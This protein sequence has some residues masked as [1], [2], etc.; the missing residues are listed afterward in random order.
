MIEH[1]KRQAVAYNEGLTY[2]NGVHIY[3][4]GG[5][6]TRTGKTVKV[7]TR[8]NIVTEKWQQLSPTLFDKM[9]AAACAIN[10]Y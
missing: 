2:Y 8:Y 10:E 4:I 5:V 7:C 9:D 6:D 3:F 1:I